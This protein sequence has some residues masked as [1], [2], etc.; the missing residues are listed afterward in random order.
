MI[1]MVNVSVRVVSAMSMVVKLCQDVI[2]HM[3]VQVAISKFFMLTLSIRALRPVFSD[4]AGLML[5]V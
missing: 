4:F 3:I 2:M 1:Q 5:R